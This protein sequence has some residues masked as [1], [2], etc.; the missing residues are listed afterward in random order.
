SNILFSNTVDS[1]GNLIVVGITQCGFD[2]QDSYGDNDGV[3][4]KFDKYGNKLWTRVLG[5]SGRDYFY[6]VASDSSGNIFVTG[7]TNS[8]W[9]ND[10]KGHI[11]AVVI[12]LDSEGNFEW[13]IQEGTTGEDVAS[14]VVVKD[15]IVYVAGYSQGNFLGHVSNGSYDYYIIKINQEGEIIDSMLDGGPSVD[16]VYNIKADNQGNLYLIGNTSSNL[17]GFTASG[18]Y[19]IHIEKYNLDLLRQKTFVIGTPLEDWGVDLAVSDDL[20]IFAVGYTQGDLGGNINAGSYDH[21]LIKLNSDFEMVFCTLTGT[22]GEEGKGQ[23]GN[24]AAF[25]GDYFYTVMNVSGEIEGGNY[26]GGTDPVIAVYDTEGN[27]VRL[28]YYGNEH[29][30]IARG[31]SAGEDFVLI[32]GSTL[33]DLPG[34]TTAGGD[35]FF[36]IK[37]SF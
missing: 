20:E 6:G 8:G 18:S 32:S 3:V 35:D 17:Y 26:Y 24:R 33:G 25:S 12:K 4:V 10:N 23:L 14:S 2:G 15:N 37:E 28:R 29:N 31:M 5:T 36:V 13:G 19:D 27:L 21:F 11:D 9:F 16:S 30:N 7:W 22:S 1:E 34:Y